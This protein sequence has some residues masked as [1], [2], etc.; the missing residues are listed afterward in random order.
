L[1]RRRQGDEALAR[2]R[3]VVGY[4]AGTCPAREAAKALEPRLFVFEAACNEVVHPKLGF[5]KR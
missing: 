3:F 5:K 1:L 4:R 2:H